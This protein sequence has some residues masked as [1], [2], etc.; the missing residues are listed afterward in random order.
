MFLVHLCQQKGPHAI[1]RWPIYGIPV[2]E[3]TID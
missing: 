3:L 1:L 2:L